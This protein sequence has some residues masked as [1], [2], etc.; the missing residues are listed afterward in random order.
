[1]NQF[2]YNEKSC[3]INNSLFVLSCE[4]NHEIFHYPIPLKPPYMPFN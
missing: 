2:E 4:F 1:M 3:I